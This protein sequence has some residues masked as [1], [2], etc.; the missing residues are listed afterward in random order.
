MHP[1]RRVVGCCTA[2]GF[3]NGAFYEVCAISETLKVTDTLTGA[4]IEC[5]AEVLS[6]HT[7]VAHAVVHNRC[8]GATIR[9]RKVILHDLASPWFRRAHL[10]VGLSRVTSGADIR[11]A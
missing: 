5:T 1:P 2:K 11:V 7:C 6:K 8:Q 4:V 9:S 3:T 10:Y